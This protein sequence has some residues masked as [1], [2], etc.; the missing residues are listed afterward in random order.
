[1]DGLKYAERNVNQLR[2]S[3]KK[4]LTSEM[5]LSPLRIVDIDIL[6]GEDNIVTAMVDISDKPKLEGIFV[7]VHSC[8]A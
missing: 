3:I 7:L 4:L 2:E 6:F 5:N 8:T 1:M